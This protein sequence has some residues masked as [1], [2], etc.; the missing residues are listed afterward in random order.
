MRDIGPG[1]VAC[2]WEA[3]L[4]LETGS[5]PGVMLMREQCARGGVQCDPNEAKKFV[6]SSRAGFG[7]WFVTGWWMPAIVAAWC[8]GETAG[9]CE[10]SVTEGKNPINC[11]S[12]GDLHLSMAC[13]STRL[14]RWGPSVHLAEAEWN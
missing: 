3:F 10:A 2:P 14:A 1:P 13:R 12:L 11:R 7:S 6:I 9:G 4:R 8:E 5:V